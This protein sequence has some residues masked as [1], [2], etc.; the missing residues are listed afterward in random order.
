MKQVKSFYH[1]G[2]I[3]NQRSLFLS[4]LD[5]QRDLDI[6]SSHLKRAV[7]D[8]QEMTL[9]YDQLLK[10][11][12]RLNKSLSEVTR[13]RDLKFKQLQTAE[14]Q[15]VKAD[16][17][18]REAWNNAEKMEETANFQKKECEKA[19]SDKY[20]CLL[21]MMSLVEE[22]K[23]SRKQVEEERRRNE[24]LL[25]KL[26]KLLQNFDNERNHSQKLSERLVCQR[27]S[28]KSAEDLKDQYRELQFISQKLQMEKDQAI[29]E[30]NELKNWAE[31]LKAH[32]DIVEK[33]KQQCQE[34]YDNAVVDCSQF[35]RKIQDLQFQLA[36]FQRQ[37]SNDKAENDELT[38]L[39]KKYQEQRDF[40]G[41]EIIKAINERDEARRERDEMYQ[42]FRDIQ[43][44]KDEALQRFL[45]E[46]GEFERRQEI[47]VAEMRALRKRLVQTEEK[48]KSLQLE[49]E[50]SFNVRHSTMVSSC[51][52]YHPDLRVTLR[53]TSIPSSIGGGSQR[54]VFFLLKLPDPPC[55]GP[56]ILSTKK[57][58]L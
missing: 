47:T 51:T 1:L 33:N 31:A 56:G 16:E 37:G 29:S 12:Q 34:S 3:L 52:F 53:W 48:L 49:S 50:L 39:V 15:A 22:T 42:Q 13:D 14:D 27:S 4:D 44:E 24:E 30:L 6:L 10:E 46:T 36:L 40:Y 11:K 8:L 21:A 20:A 17:Q 2:K 57:L 7:A 55:V 54:R 45:L 28:V 43:K 23:Q 25:C 18:A 35:K 32:Y 19:V 38:R 26:Q 41:E 5:P 58:V 9:R